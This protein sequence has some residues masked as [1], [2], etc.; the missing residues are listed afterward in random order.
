MVATAEVTTME[1]LVKY[2][3][4]VQGV[5]HSFSENLD[6]MNAQ[7]FDIDEQ[8]SS[9]IEVI[10]TRMGVDFNRHPMVAVPRATNTLHEKAQVIQRLQAGLEVIGASFR[11]AEVAVLR[12]VGGDKS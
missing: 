10:G 12:A 8:V 5:I 2:L 4:W 9:A 7:M 11:D 6:K 3:S 1:E